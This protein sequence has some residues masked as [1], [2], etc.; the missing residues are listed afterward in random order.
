MIR[1]KKR[2]TSKILRYVKMV[3]YP[4]YRTCCCDHIIR[5]LDWS[6]ERMGGWPGEEVVRYLLVWLNV[7][8]HG[9]KQKVLRV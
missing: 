8:S 1:K 9:E 6:G 2:E 3:L 5:V 4:A 7:W